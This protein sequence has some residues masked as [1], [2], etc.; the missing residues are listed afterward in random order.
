MP[1]KPNILF[2]GNYN[3]KDYL[4]MFSK[5]KGH[6]NFFF[7]E[8]A[9]PREITSKH[10]KEFGEAIFWGDYY[11][12][13]DLLEK[14]KPYK[15]I[16]LFI[17]AYNHVALNIACKEKGITTCLLDHGVRSTH[18]NFTYAATSVQPKNYFFKLNSSLPLLARVRNRIFFYNS[19]QKL[20]PENK[21]F[22]KQ[23]Y[24]IRKHNNY[25]QTS[26]L[27]QHN[28]RKPDVYLSFSAGVFAAHQKLDALPDTQKVYYFGIP[29]FD[30][31]TNINFRNTGVTQ[32]LFIDQALVS[33]QLLGWTI[34]LKVLFVEE[35]VRACKI[36]NIKLVIK[37]HPLENSKVWEAFE[38]NNVSLVSNEDFE[39]AVSTSTIIAGFYSTLLLGLAALPFTT[40]LT[41]ENHPAGNFA[42]SSFLTNAGVAKSLENVHEFE[43]LVPKLAQINQ[44]QVKHKSTFITKWLYRL[45][46]NAG[47]R[48]NKLLLQSL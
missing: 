45:D 17:E 11:N 34:E 29:Y 1:V 2:V 22:L 16:F 26:Q 36:H 48:L 9:S 15:V 39:V 7:L 38:G 27:L 14:V 40:V 5:S 28:L 21:Q 3:R 42:L 31:F 44:E 41:F 37:T 13:F 43:N 20:L 46:G 12:A 35:L 33:Q 18:I 30:H 6:F 25:L 32:L 8:F 10:Y 19:A 23:F 47:I 24:K 4:D